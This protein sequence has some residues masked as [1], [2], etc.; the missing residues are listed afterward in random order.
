VIAI[1]VA[2]GCSRG[3]TSDG[4][5]GARIRLWHTFNPAET[6]ALNQALAGRAGTHRVETTLLPFQRGQTILREV[7]ERADECPDL[8]RMD[9]TW[10]PEL[11]RA[12]VLMP[13]PAD[14][15]ARRQWLPEAADLA[16]DRGVDYALPQSIDGLA[17][18]YRKDAVR[19]VDWPPRTVNELIAT[20]RRL[21]EGGNHGL[22]VRVDGYW[23]G[24]FLRGWGG[25]LLDPDQGYLGIDQPLA[26]EAL[27]RFAE[28]FSAR[29]ISGLP[30]PTGNEAQVEVRRFRAGAIAVVMNGPWAVTDLGAGDTSGLGVAPFPSDPRGRG[31]AP[32][33]GQMFVVPTCA[34][35]PQAAW[36]LAFELTAPELQASWARRF[37]VVPTTE[38]ALADAGPF[39]QAFYQALQRA[40]PLPRHPISAEI[41]DDLNPA[42]GAVVAGDATAA[43][44]LDGAVRA[45]TRLLARHELPVRV[46]PPR[47]AGPP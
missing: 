31:A 45:W 46:P 36:A 5:G 6:E 22:G 28:F 32:R 4:G 20:A 27:D 13:V 23:F 35:E 26:K 44:A 38:A 47:D 7:V 25:E 11:A 42:I 30:P 34:R 39:S 18:I 19:G 1:A 37:G 14:L 21:T 33:G 29:G 3:P 2:S 17:L 41:F 16:R 24:A 10:I 9:A 40:R 12:G 43:D 8:V 15:M